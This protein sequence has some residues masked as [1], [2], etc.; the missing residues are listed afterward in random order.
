M[1]YSPPLTKEERLL[2]QSTHLNIRVGVVSPYLAHAI[3]SINE[4]QRTC[5]FDEVAVLEQMNKV[6][7]IATIN[8]NY[9]GD[10]RGEK[11]S[12]HLPDDP[13]KKIDIDVY[14]TLGGPRAGVDESKQYFDR[15]AVEIINAVRALFGHDNSMISDSMTGISNGESS[16]RN[17][18]EPAKVMSFMSMSQDEEEPLVNALWGGSEEMIGFW[19]YDDPGKCPQIR[20]QESSL[21]FAVPRE[22]IGGNLI[23]VKDLVYC[24][25]L[26]GDSKCCCGFVEMEFFPEKK[27]YRG[28]ISVE[29]SDNTTREGYFIAGYCPPG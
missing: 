12:L 21:V 10:K 24:Y 5:L 16:C 19:I 1:K 17:I 13:S 2:L 8:N 29:M 26:N 15:L 9:R 4:L 14:Y 6:D 20:K 11:F 22:G 27:Q 23:N 3:G 7:V 25:E 28:R 18:S